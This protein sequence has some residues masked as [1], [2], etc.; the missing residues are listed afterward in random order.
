[1]K[2]FIEVHE[3]KQPRLINL[4]QVMQIWPKADG[5]TEI[6]FAFQDSD[7]IEAE[8]ILTTESYEQI[9]SMISRAQ[10]GIPP[11]LPGKGV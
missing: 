6:Y 8:W 3:G 1:M 2:K 7:S 5:G 11:C 10:G 4:S 9:R